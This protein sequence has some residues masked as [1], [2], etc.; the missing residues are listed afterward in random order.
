M[1]YVWHTFLD[2]A[3]EKAPQLIANFDKNDL[4]SV[5]TV[6]KTGL[7]T[8][9]GSEFYFFIWFLNSKLFIEYVREKVKVLASNFDKSEL[10]HVEPEVK[11]DVAGMLF[12]IDFF[13]CL[14]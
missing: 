11:N 4:K 3:K 14:I 1:Y 12:T 9:D 10:K 2:I 5:E 7:P 8:P 13:L 6:V